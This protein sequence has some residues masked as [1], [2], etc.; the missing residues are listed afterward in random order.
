MLGSLACW[1]CI[2]LSQLANGA[3]TLSPISI[4]G[5]RLYKSNGD[6]FFA[7]GITYTLAYDNKVRDRL[8]D[9]KQCEIDAKLMADMGVNTVRVY[10]VDAQWSHDGCMEAFDKQGIYIWIELD[11]ALTVIDAETPDWTMTMYDDWTSKIDE[12]AKYSNVLAFGVSSDSINY[13]YYGKSAPYIRAAVRDM[14][15]FRDARGYRHI[16]I[17]Y[18]QWDSSYLKKTAVDYLTCGEYADSIDLFGLNLFYSCGEDLPLMYHEFVEAQI[19]VLLSEI[20]CYDTEESRNFSEIADT[21][22]LGSKGANY[23]D[24][25][26]GGIV[27]DWPDDTAS[28]G[29][30][31]YPDSSFTGTPTLLS[32]YTNLAS[33]FRSASPTGTA[34]SSYDVTTS[35]APACPTQNDG[36]ASW[37]VDPKAPLPTIP[38]LRSVTR[39]DGTITAKP[40]GVAAQNTAAKGRPTG[41]AASASGKD[42][43]GGG[44]HKPDGGSSSSAQSSDSSN[45]KFSVGAMVGVIVGGSAGLFV[46]IGLGW[47]IIRRR[48]RNAAA[49]RNADA[50]A[51]GAGGV[52]GMVGG[53]GGGWSGSDSDHKG[54]YKPHP[55]YAPTNVYFGP[56]QEMP[57]EGEPAVVR[58]ELYSGD[59]SA[60]KPMTGMDNA[61]G[62][63]AAAAA[64]GEG[65]YYS[66]PK[67]LGDMAAAAEPQ[68]PSE[69]SHVQ[70]HGMGEGGR[71]A[72]YQLH[73]AVSDCTAPTPWSSPPQPAHAFEIQGGVA[74]NL[75]HTGDLDGY[76]TQQQQQ[77]GLQPQSQQ[78]QQ[79]QTPPPPSQQQPHQP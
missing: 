62:Y 2:L 79:Q 60:M 30:V 26:S 24:V 29:V 67:A 8:A 50:Q 19:P 39:A 74:D 38:G 28:W 45:R 78:Q 9:P 11:S 7:K 32:H 12:F 71:R 51:S 69:L 75:L 20:G 73:T 68:T 56:R 66:K 36:S 61:M 46:L 23:L 13:S 43:G 55:E 41:A 72:S 63:D 35:S 37:M 17:A 44:S 47:F 22:G 18:S 34:A 33:I 10:E 14:K 21:L 16:P 42:A 25:F 59:Y 15:A 3:T 64:A 53:D 27:Y 54:Y 40:T 5:R 1:A 31:Q 65:G 52:G 4:K 6:E 76:Q 58:Y 48:R 77:Q 57:G 49:Q 70:S